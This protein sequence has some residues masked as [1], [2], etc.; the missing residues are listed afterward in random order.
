MQKN[1]E[2]GFFSDS[3]SVQS[4]RVLYTPSP[5]ARSSLLHLQ[6]AG[7]L[8]A[9]RPHTSRREG[10]QSYL[11]F[12]V[13]RGEGSLEYA[14]R[15]YALRA[16]DVAFVDCRRAYA[17]STGEDGQT[18][19]WCLQWCHFYG[20]SMPAVYAKYCERGGEPVLRARA[21]SAY[22][23]LMTEIDE[24]ARSDDYIRDMRINERLN[25][26]L[27]LLM[28]SSW[29]QSGSPGAPKKLEMQ[30]VKAY[31]DEHFAEKLTLETVA[32]R[33]Y[34]DKCYLTRLFKEQVGMTLTAYVQQVRITHA[35]RMLRFTDR[36][37]EQIGLEC[38]IG[39]PNYFS[40]VFRKLEG[41]CP[42]EFRRMW[43]QA[44]GK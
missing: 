37:V 28:E 34:I 36:S 27:T 44:Q 10:L 14:G 33:F 16:G 3:P 43:R 11:C 22:T 30:R 38:G 26:L 9:L 5:F 1:Q 24:L 20:P 31:V 17:H 23:A 32:G 15:R 29:H 6:E 7:T 8:E 42:S 12:A 25:A 18:G 35:K 19:L 13:T 39:E 4:E 41:V 21:L 40:R 2:G